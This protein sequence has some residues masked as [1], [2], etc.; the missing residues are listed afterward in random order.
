MIH[1]KLGQLLFGTIGLCF[2][3]GMLTFWPGIIA[4]A[5]RLT[6]WA[7]STDP[8]MRAEWRYAAGRITD[9]AEDFGFIVSISEINTSL[10]QGNTLTVQRQDCAGGQDFAGNTYTGTLTYDSPTATYSFEDSSNQ[11]LVNWR[12]DNSAQVYTLTVATTELSLT[13]VTMVPQ[14]AL[15]DEGGDGNIKVGRIGN[16]LV[17]SNYYAD[18]T[19]LEIGG[20]EKGVA[21]VDMQVLLRGDDTTEVSNDYDHRWFAL[22][23]NLNGGTQAW[24]SAW[25]IEDFDGP[26]WTVTIATGSD[27]TWNIFSVTEEDEGALAEPLTVTTLAR[28]NL[29]ASTGLDISTGKK[30]HL[31]AGSNQA[32]DLLDIQITVPEGQFITSNIQSTSDW[33]EEAVGIQ[34][35]G[36]ISGTEISEVR[37]VAA[38][39]ST[40][41]DPLTVTFLPLI[42]KH[43]P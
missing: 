9:G 38:E 6:Q 22:A 33:L 3:A 35:E 34:V 28:Q 21:R 30:W 27:T 41:F 26:Y 17:D 37:M 4:A 18:W 1:K 13:N 19:T 43:S 5:D 15:I 39:S 25:K 7:P 12:W 14:G 42:I 11:E 2:L 23:A 40:E 16:I 29:P 20:V 10:I 36:R 24:V 32:N 8:L 31:T